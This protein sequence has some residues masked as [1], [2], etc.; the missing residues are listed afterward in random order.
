MQLKLLPFASIALVKMCKVYCCRYRAEKKLKKK[1]EKKFDRTS[2]NRNVCAPWIEFGDRLS[3]TQICLRQQSQHRWLQ[4][5]VLKAQSAI[6]TVSSN[7][8]HTIHICGARVC[9]I[10]ATLWVESRPRANVLHARNY[11]YWLF[12]RVQIR[13]NRKLRLTHRCYHKI[14]LMVFW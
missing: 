2:A 13:N 9:T 8:P 10:C 1:D 11:S 5:V 7:T 4:L 6:V 14:S 3:A 12:R